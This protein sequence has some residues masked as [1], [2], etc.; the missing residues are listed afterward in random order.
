[1]ALAALIVFPKAYTS[2]SA[3]ALPDYVS[4]LSPARSHRKS[5][6]LEKDVKEGFGEK[7]AFAGFAQLSLHMHS[8]TK[9]LRSPLK[10]LIK[11]RLWT[12]LRCSR[13]FILEYKKSR[14]IRCDCSNGIP[15]PPLYSF[16]SSSRLQQ[17]INLPWPITKRRDLR[18]TLISIANKAI[19]TTVMARAT[20]PK[21]IQERT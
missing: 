19:A 21:D 4:P 18:L 5:S 8:L 6:M 1:M 13:P 10:K 15:I 12:P 17:I 7:R 20:N 16:V 9:K 2:A 11:S 14:L 3:L